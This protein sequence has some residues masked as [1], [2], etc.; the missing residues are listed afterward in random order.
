[1]P[2][3]FLPEG[4]GTFIECTCSAWGRF[5][6]WTWEDVPYYYLAQ[7]SALMYLNFSLFDGLFDVSGDD[8]DAV[9][10][11]LDLNF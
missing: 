2:D 4:I 11:M 3:A 7:H 8:D 9:Q 6:S 5:T 1:M 10:Q